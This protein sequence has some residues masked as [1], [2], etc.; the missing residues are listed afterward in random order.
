MQLLESQLLEGSHASSGALTMEEEAW[1][2]VE[3]QLGG[4]P[5]AAAIGAAFADTVL[6]P[7]RLSRPALHAALGALGSGVSREAVLGADLADLRLQL[8][9]WVAAIPAAAAS[10]AAAA[11]SAGAGSPAAATLAR[12]S[13]LLAAYSKAWQAA[14]A[15]L[16]LLQLPAQGDSG[17][18]LLLLR[19]G[20]AV[21]ALRPAAAPELALHDALPGEWQQAAAGE[22]R[23]AE[24]VLQAAAAV[25]DAAGGGQLSRCGRSQGCATGQRAVLPRRVSPLAVQLSHNCCLPLSRPT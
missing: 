16:A 24:A 23:Q 12:W 21:T 2:A 13:A 9:R 15:P 1:R 19:R 17:A 10:A 25:Y 6:A 14:H 7:G 8:P 4:A 3:S 22:A 5:P 20:G 11:G 18:L